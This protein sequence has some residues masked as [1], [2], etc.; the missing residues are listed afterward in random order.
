MNSFRETYDV[1]K[2]GFA[3]ENLD[4]FFDK[5]TQEDNKKQIKKFLEEL[6]INNGEMSY[7][8]VYAR[9]TNYGRKYSYGIQGVSKKIRNYLLSGSGVVDYDIKNAHPT[10]LYYLCVKHKIHTEKQL[11]KSYVFNRD[12][13]IQEHFQK[14]LYNN[15]DVKKLILTATNCDDLLFTDNEWLVDYQNEMVFIREQLQ[16]QKDYKKILFD[17]EKLKQD[18]RN[19]NSSFVNRILCKVESEIIDKITAFIMKRGYEVFALMFDG[20]MVY[21]GTEELL[22][23]IN[24]VVQTAYGDYFYITQKD[25]TTDVDDNGYKIDLDQLLGNIDSME[26]RMKRFI[27]KFHPI[28]IINP[29]LYGIKLSDGEYSFH[30]KDAFIQAT[31]HI[32]YTNEKNQQATVVSKWLNEYIGEDDIYDNII[33]DPEYTGTDDF[34]LWTDWD[35]NSW[36]GEW[37]YNEKAVEYYRQHIKVLCNYDEGVAESIEL[38]IAHLFKYPK[39]K[40]FVPIF[41]GN[42]GTGKDMLIA[43]ITKLMGEKKKFETSTPEKNIW[44]SFNPFMKSAVLI[45]LSEFGKK[46][47]QDY[48]GNIKAITTTGRI[49]INEKNKGEYEINSYHRFIGASNYGEPI[50]IEKDNRRFQLI[51]TSSDKIGNTEYFNEGWG[52]IK[53]K[54][55]MKSFYDYLMTLDVPEQ[56]QYHMVPQSEYT[57]YITGISKPQEECFLQDFIHENMKSGKIEKFRTMDMYDK[58]LKWCDETKQSYKLEKRK[59]LVHLK[60]A[61]NDTAHIN[62]YKSSGYMY[63]KFDWDALHTE[64]KYSKGEEEECDDI[65]GACS[66]EEETA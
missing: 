22:E 64:G 35:V 30:K 20:L 32:K 44:G 57:E 19:F 63:A 66:E 14:E 4:S 28:K 25:I 27:D 6:L 7:D 26:T 5:Q 47:T 42:Q 1:Q 53:D 51:L 48:V 62:V 54:N 15:E 39:N 2:L 61:S 36:E 55:A 8:Y 34:N 23:Q 40:S 13:V 3:L 46:N 50:P 12:Q 49:M 41:V 58:Y 43:L 9:Y 38:W 59:F 56:L 60:K 17:T 33:T 37:T 10:I 16:K 11:L 21:N 31:E 65:E 29:P 45:H 52:Y 24:L 18:S